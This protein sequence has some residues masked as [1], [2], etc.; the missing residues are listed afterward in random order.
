M[1]EK[2]PGCLFNRGISH[3]ALF[4]S[5]AGKDENCHPR[6]ILES[7]TRK[8]GICGGTLSEHGTSVLIG[9]TVISGLKS[10]APT[11]TNINLSSRGGASS[12]FSY[13][14]TCQNRV[15][16][17]YFARPHQRI[18]QNG[19]LAQL[20]ERLNGIEKVSGSNPLC[21][22]LRFFGEKTWVNS[23]KCGKAVF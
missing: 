14:F 4:L 16:C 13:F 20:V 11:T 12:K 2:S 10:R 18:L 1:N 3:T 19:V 15:P 23:K 9:S 8:I 6:P 7:S 17:V 5:R 21:S 22:S